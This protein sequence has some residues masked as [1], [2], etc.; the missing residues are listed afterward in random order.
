MGFS[1]SNEAAI[2]APRKLNNPLPVVNQWIFLCVMSDDVRSIDAIIE[3][4]TEMEEYEG[5]TGVDDILDEADIK[6][7][8]YEQRCILNTKMSLHRDCDT[9][10]AVA[11]KLASKDNS[12]AV[13]PI[14]I[15]NNEH[16]EQARVLL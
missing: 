3:D 1:F 12:F 5:F 10:D 13:C 2:W 14:P 15:Y 4:M 8:R 6:P 9:W 7:Y 16:L 11:T